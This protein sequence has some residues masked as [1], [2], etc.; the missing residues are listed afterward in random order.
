VDTVSREQVLRNWELNGK[1]GALKLERWC[2]H[3]ALAEKAGPGSLVFCD[4][5]GGE[6][7]L[8]DPAKCPILARTDVLVEVHE[9]DKRTVEANAREL[10]ARFTGTH[11][12]RSIAHAGTVP[13]LSGVEILQGLELAKACNEGRPYQQ[14][15]LWMKAFA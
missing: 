11:H 7:P 4:I 8:L 12:I 2:D 15:W 13:A 5:E 6:M 10:A 3:D 1:P 9:T 14:V